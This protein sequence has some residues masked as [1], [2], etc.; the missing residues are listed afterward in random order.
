MNTR[1]LLLVPLLV[2]AALLLPLTAGC[3][4]DTARG[5]GAGA[6]LGGIG[7][8]IIGHQSGETGGGAALG[9][10]VGGAVGGGVGAASDYNKRQERE[11][12]AYDAGYG[13][14]RN[15]DRRTYDDGYRRGYDRGYGTGYGTGYGHGYRPHD[16]RGR[17]CRVCH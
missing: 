5:A 7:G 16:C 9:A 14:A 8:A 12:Y 15:D 1:R 6:V 13:Q 2:V 10:L 3:Q 4:S 17:Y 11:A